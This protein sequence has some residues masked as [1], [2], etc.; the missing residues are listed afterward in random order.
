MVHVVDGGA[1]CPSNLV[2]VCSRHHHRLHQPGWSATLGEEAELVVSDP[3]GRHRT[4]H[5]PGHSPR[6]PPEVFAA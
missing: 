4:S 5:P 6:P 3:N 1:T 2:L